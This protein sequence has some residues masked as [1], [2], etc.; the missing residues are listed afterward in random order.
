[1][2]AFWDK[3]KKEDGKKPEAKKGDAVKKE[4]SKKKPVQP[5]KNLPVK[6]N[7][8]LKNKG[9]KEKRVKPI[10]FEEKADLITRAIV[11]P[12]VSEDAM[13]KEAFSKYV[14]VVGKEA[15]KKTVAQAVEAR[16]GVKV[17]K[18]NIVNYKPKATQFR[19]RK[20]MRKGYK[21]AIV[22]IESGKKIELFSN[23]K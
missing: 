21:K 3:F 8:K 16:Y 10:N 14:F 4:D 12:V 19:F 15:N 11:R 22:T 6:E 17:L 7:K 18:V 23:K 5:K 13:S 9:S 2:S 1:M 20:G